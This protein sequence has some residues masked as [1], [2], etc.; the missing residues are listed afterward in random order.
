MPRT[1]G[2]T[3]DNTFIKGLITEATGL[4]FPAN[5]CTETFNCIFNLDGSIER[6]KGL[7]YEA[8][9]AN[10]SVDR[11]NS[12][13]REFLWEA[14]SGTGTIN[15]TVIQVG[16]V[17]YF[18]LNPDSGSISTHLKSFTIDL[19]T[20][21]YKPSGAPNPQTQTCQFAS[22]NGYLFVTHPTLLPFYVKYDAGSDT[23]TSKTLN[24]KFR[25]FDGLEDG[26]KIDERTLQ[27]SGA[28]TK[29]HKYNLFNQGFNVT[30][31][32]VGSSDENVYDFWVAHRL[33]YPSNADVW[34]LY[35]NAVGAF[36][37][38][39]FLMKYTG[40][41]QAPRGHHI[42]DVFNEDRSAISGI[43]GIAAV[44]SSYFRPSTVAFYA[45]R[46]F[47]GGVGY[48]KYSTKIWFTQIITKDEQLEFCYQKEDPTSEDGGDLLPS[49]GGVIKIQ[50][51]GNIIKFVTLQG[52][53]LVVCSNGVWSI[54]GS[55]T[56]GFKATDYSIKK[57]SSVPTPK[58]TDSFVDVDG[59]PI[60][61]TLNGIYSANISD[62]GTATVTNMT[63]TT[64]KT[65]FDAIASEGRTYSKGSYN[66]TT[67]VVTW[68]YR[69][70]TAGS[71]LG[72]YNYTRALNLNT[73]TGAFYP[74][75][76]D[77]TVTLNGIIYTQDGTSHFIVSKLTSGTTYNMTFAES[78]AT[79]YLDWVA[80]TTDGVDYSSYFISG[81]KIDG[82]AITKVQS[83]FVYVF[84]EKVS[85]SSLYMQAVWNYANTGNSGK[86]SSRQQ[87]YHSNSKYDILYRRLK[88]RGDG[89]ALQMKFISQSGMPF[90]IIGWSVAESGNQ[91]P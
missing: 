75:T 42:L 23:I 64:I 81:Y 73:R 22:G 12:V 33:D 9:H 72:R 83:N 55:D 56:A 61:W 70:T 4:N 25:D 3:L 66:R 38:H 52:Q 60:W 41:S 35:R 11:S 85:G 89:L 51:A 69:D 77:T 45:G 43:T 63:D 29:E 78:N 16:S 71:V 57:I 50:D 84:M 90:H 48:D 28:I 17:I 62:L 18:Y 34:W 31:R 91:A 87:C 40:N 58:D 13:T 54:S 7:E 47:Y 53:L 79:T 76:F 80:A 1:V 24:L 36:D 27:A 14:A 68:L 21:T 88:V 46:V 20:G 5:A 2:K 82:S 65:F 86:F 49:D 32:C 10:K 19:N 6:R 39:D 26:L 15:F 59:V 74:W 30:T 8:S 67:K 44:T 37:P